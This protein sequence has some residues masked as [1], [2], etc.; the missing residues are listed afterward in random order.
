MG[1]MRV[2]GAARCVCIYILVL[3]TDKTSQRHLVK[4]YVAEAR[5]QC[6][7]AGSRCSSSIVIKAP[8]ILS[9]T[10]PKPLMRWVLVSAVQ[11]SHL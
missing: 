9:K 7:Q 2:D 10:R 8:A 5:R 3:Q 6:Q 11:P 1:W 4:C